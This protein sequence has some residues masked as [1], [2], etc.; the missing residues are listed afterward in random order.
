M[1]VGRRGKI[2][3]ALEEDLAGSGFEE[4]ATAD[5]FG[6]Y[7]VGVVDDAGEVV[8]GETGVLQIVAKR[9]APDEEVAEVSACSEGLGAEVAVCE[10][11]RCAV[12][13]LEDGSAWR[14]PGSSR[15]CG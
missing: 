13:E 1:Q 2:E 7:G 10:G 6:N 12:E 5:Y 8:A 14:I 3:G 4:V 9:F 11:Y 15:W